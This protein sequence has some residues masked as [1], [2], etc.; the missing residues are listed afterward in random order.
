ME[1]LIFDVQ[2]TGHFVLCR[3]QYVMSYFCTV[4]SVIMPPPLDV[5]G[6]II[7]EKVFPVFSE[8][9][10]FTCFGLVMLLLELMGV[11]EKFAFQIWKKE[12]RFARFYQRTFERGHIYGIFFRNYAPPHFIVCIFTV[13]MPFFSGKPAENVMGVYGFDCPAIF[14][15][16][17]CS[18]FWGVAEGVLVH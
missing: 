13:K 10:F 1:H 3:Y 14:W 6:G 18:H 11:T 17:E 8:S 4:I 5:K 16:L 9:F 12:H 7:T 2:S 15:D